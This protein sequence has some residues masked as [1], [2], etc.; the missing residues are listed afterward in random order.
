MHLCSLQTGVGVALGALLGVMVGVVVGVVDGVEHQH[1]RALRLHQ[2]RLE[3]GVDARFA[4]RRR[5]PAPVHGGRPGR[6]PR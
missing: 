1:A 2:Q 3:H 4:A 6:A 5:V